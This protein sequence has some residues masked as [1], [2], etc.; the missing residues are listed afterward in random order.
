MKYTA[1]WSLLTNPSGDSWSATGFNSD[2]AQPSPSNPLGNP[3]FPGHTSSNSTIW[4]DFLTYQYNASYLQTYNLAVGGA[5]LDNDIVPGFMVPIA[6][7]IYNIFMPYYG[8][9]HKPAWK[10]TNT[11]FIMF[12]GIND[13]VNM[14]TKANA[15]EV[16]AIDANLTL[17]YSR[18][19]E[20][21]YGA[22]ARN[23][24]L[25]NVPPLERTWQ[26][27]AVR[28]TRIPKFKAGVVSWNQRIE[29]VVKGLKTQH[30]DASVFLF[31]TNQLLH[32]A[33]DDPTR[34]PATRS[35]QN[36]SEFC[37]LYAG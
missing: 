23:F 22:G 6:T 9:A 31:D 30:S 33:L 27:E 15:M 11:L 24:L 36:T 20:A 7:Q 37:K 8:S 13:I 2:G 14:E 16:A 32:Q 35:I 26:E 25:L 3:A 29:Q 5:T 18:Y 28:K 19:L 4:I 17:A 34:F 10:A 1:R 21:L 12:C